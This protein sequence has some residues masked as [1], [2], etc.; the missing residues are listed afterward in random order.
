MAVCLE[1]RHDQCGERGNGGHQR[2]AGAGGKQRQ[3][4]LSLRSFDQC[5]HRAIGSGNLTLCGSCSTSGADGELVNLPGAL[6]DVQGDSSITYYCNTELVINQGV[7]RKS[8]G[9]GTTT[10]QPT[11]IN[12]GILMSR[13]A[14]S[15][16]TQRPGQRRISAR[17]G[18]D[19]EFSHQL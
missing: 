17:S 2:A 13:P 4:L 14:P 12:S 5:W 15:T 16:S 11:F 9:T 7:M 19:V 8:G 6:V 18:R 3:L 1:R 10:I